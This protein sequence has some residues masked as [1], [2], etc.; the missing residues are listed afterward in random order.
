MTLVSSERCDYYQENID[1]LVLDSFSFLSLPSSLLLT[2]ISVHFFI[3]LFFNH[4]I[5]KLGKTAAFAHRGAPYTFDPFLLAYALSNIKHCNPTNQIWPGWD[6]A[7]KDPSYDELIQ[8]PPST[9][10]IIIE[11]LYLLLDVEPWNGLLCGSTYSDILYHP[12]NQDPKSKQS[13]PSTTENHEK[14]IEKQSLIDYGIFL[15]CDEQTTLDRGSVRNFKAG[16][17]DT[18]EE[19]IERWKNND[20][21]NGRFLVSHLVQDKIKYR[22]TQDDIKGI[23]ML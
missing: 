14:Q 23:D 16:I 3:L 12:D 22:L 9:T 5:S 13:S 7:K 4:I 18:L 2:L 11:G 21:K 17:T 1:H 19:S 10:L 20:I 6:H 15:D 8:I